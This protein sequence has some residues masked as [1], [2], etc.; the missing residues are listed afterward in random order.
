[1]P[2]SNESKLEKINSVIEEMALLGYRLDQLLEGFKLY[3]SLKGTLDIS[4]YENVLDMFVKGID[5]MGE[6]MFRFHRLFVEL[7]QTLEEK[8]SD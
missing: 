7:K 3:N 4:E 1:M 2:V 6:T 8:G 5:A